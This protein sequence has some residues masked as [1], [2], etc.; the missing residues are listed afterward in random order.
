M[1]GAREGPGSC[2]TL[3]AGTGPPL[4]RCAEPLASCFSVW[5]E[6]SMHA[7]CATLGPLGRAKRGCRPCLEQI[8]LAS[9]MQG[10]GLA[11]PAASCLA[12]NSM[13]I[14]TQPKLQAARVAVLPCQPQGLR[15]HF[16][17][18]PNRQQRPAEHKAT[19]LTVPCITPLAAQQLQVPDF[20]T[21]CQVC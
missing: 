7:S 15:A 9:S 16:S 6:V 11:S 12:T 3:G 17:L 5:A 21:L 19:S 1:L 20:A 14:C 10:H 13:P 18:V 8:S 4:S 2:I